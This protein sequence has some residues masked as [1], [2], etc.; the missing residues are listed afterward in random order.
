MVAYGVLELKPKERFGLANMSQRLSADLEKERAEDFERDQIRKLVSDELKRYGLLLSREVTT[1]GIGWR[2][3]RNA[4]V[5]FGQLQGKPGFT[6][7]DELFRGDF[8]ECC[9][10]AAKILDALD[11]SQKPDTAAG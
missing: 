6:H 1:S 10:E 3:R 11:A 5:L 4:C 7:R 8:R 2:T 9:I